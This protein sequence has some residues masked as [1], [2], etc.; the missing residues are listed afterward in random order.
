[1]RILII[2]DGRST[3]TRSWIKGLLPYQDE[4]HLIT[5]YPCE[6][7]E[8]IKSLIFLPLAF[9]QVGR[10]QAASEI[11]T[12]FST[13]EK[14]LVGKT[15]SRFRKSF[16]AAR[17]TLGPLSLSFTTGKYR[18]IIESLKPDLIHALRIPFEGMIAAY[19][20]PQYPLIIST[21]GN[22]F[23]LH[24][25][26][27]PFMKNATRKAVQRAD[28]FMADC[29]RD[30]RLVHDW[31]LQENIPTMFA[32]G[33]G[34]LDMELIRRKMN[35]KIERELAVINPRG[36]RPV[37]VRNDLFFESLPTILKEYPNLP[38]YN[39]AMLGEHD[40]ENW[41]RTF[42]LPDNVQLLPGMP[43][44]QLWDYSLRSRVVVS[45]AIHDGTPNSVLESMALGCVPVVGDIESLREWIVDGENGLLV[46]PNN[47]S[48]IATG[49]LRALRDDDLFSRAQQINSKL[50]QE[51]ADRAKVMPEVHAFYVKIAGIKSNK[52]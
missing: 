39:A 46:N 8:G 51:K 48:S 31:G 18:G 13:T 29:Q 26:K 42:N 11:R 22:D 4:I 40:A 20:P 27:T 44:E 14:S 25:N 7:M 9:S 6:M 3:T 21:W 23:T 16:L 47:P 28:G 15:I 2:A 19:T 52:N 34:G 32:P 24:A 43:Q 41:K 17:Y 35:S 36:I 10:K 50:I 38:V 37:Y 49:I 1:M 30:I 33:S 45:A 5:T 12:S